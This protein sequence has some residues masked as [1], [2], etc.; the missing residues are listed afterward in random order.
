MEA[1]TKI[2]GLGNALE[3]MAKRQKDAEEKISLFA[4]NFEQ[5]TGYK[6]H[7]QINAIDV[8]RIMFRFYGEPK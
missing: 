1:E 2:E 4:H 3:E 7:A 6:P 8:V 5:M